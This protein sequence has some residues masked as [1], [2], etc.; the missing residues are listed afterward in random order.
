MGRPQ[1]Q[2]SRPAH[3]AAGAGDRRRDSGWAAAGGPTGRGL[4]E[5]VSGRVEGAA[6]RDL[7]PFSLTR[8]RASAVLCSVIRLANPMRAIF[9][10]S[11]TRDPRFRRYR[12]LQ[13]LGQHPPVPLHRS[14][15]PP[16]PE[17]HDA[18][19][20]GRQGP[21]R[22]QHCAPGPPSRTEG[23]RYSRPGF[24]PKSSRLWRS[25]GLG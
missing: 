1:E 15:S 2:G 19:L 14:G 18:F 21:D 7:G 11:L 17:T 9:L 23:G 3:N 16:L 6:S 20:P 22:R 25:S 13:P 10:R 12:L 5:A 24:L 4:A 8:S